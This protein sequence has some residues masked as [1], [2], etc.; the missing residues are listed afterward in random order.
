MRVFKK[1]KTAKRFTIELR[2]HRRVVRRFMGLA[3]RRQS[4]QLGRR[5][6]D[7]IG[8]RAA[9]LSPDRET[10]AWLEASPA[11]LKERLAKLGIIDASRVSA[12]KSLS[13]LLEDFTAHLAAKE[14][15]SAH[16]KKTAGRL[17]RIFEGC[18]FAA[19]SDIAP[20][21]VER[22][23]KG[24]RDSGLSPRTSNQYLTALKTFCGWMVSSG[25]V[26]ENPVRSLR[27]VNE[28]TDLRRQR[29]AATPD[30]LRRL[31]AATASGPERYGMTGGERALLYRF[32]AETGLRANEARMLTAGA[33]D[34]DGLTV[35]VK[36][37]YSKHRE[38]DTV[39]LRNDLAEA[40]RKHLAG[41]LPTA[42]V[43]GGRYVRLTKRTAEMLRADLEA[44]NVSY[45]DEQGRVFDFHGTRHTYITNLR[46]APSRVAQKL[47]R[48]KSSAMTDRYT[49]VRMHDERA[50]L[51]LLP[52]VTTPMESET[53]EKTGTNDMP[54]GEIPNS[55]SDIRKSGARHGAPLD[56]N[57]RNTLEAGRNA[58]P[59]FRYRER[60]F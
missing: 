60:G 56:T 54:V 3:D 40:L 51:D 34:L 19:F 52:D 30:E 18:L 46:H 17:R 2:D 13:E 32:C 49:H 27:K 29:R 36:A 8:F 28:N 16:I 24:M 22:F 44:A 11:A 59:R 48:H 7:L 41:K 42:K 37:A 39:P 5:I 55:A 33:F 50:A 25:Q 12:A 35:T 58:R 15:T 53:A 45:E 4:E 20:G 57:G 26:T 31:I 9:R 23:L 6:E 1:R 21:K 38:T 43:F 14:D 10:V 47:A